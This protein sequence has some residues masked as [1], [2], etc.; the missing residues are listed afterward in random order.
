MKYGFMDTWKQKC[1][2]HNGLKNFAVTKN[3]TVGQVERESH[4]SFFWHPRV[5][6]NIN[7]YI[8]G[9][10]YILVSQ[11]AETFMRKC[12][13]KKTSVVEKQLLVPSS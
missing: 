3:G 8:R 13:Q 1:N 2:L 7:S 12:Q 5:L 4:V 10:Y 11:S 6:Y 9:R